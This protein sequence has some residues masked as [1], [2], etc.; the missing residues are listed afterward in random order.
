MIII[1]IF[2]I[3]IVIIIVLLTIITITTIIISPGCWLVWR[4]IGYCWRSLRVC[5]ENQIHLQKALW[6]AGFRFSR[7]PK[8]MLESQRTC[9]FFYFNFPINLIGRSRCFWCR[10]SGW[11]SW[12]LRSWESC[13]GCT[14]HNGHWAKVAKSWF[15]RTCIL[16]TSTSTR[17]HEGM[18]VRFYQS[19]KM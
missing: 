8:L 10:W 7:L 6:I 17:P 4:N 3:T 1:T 15:P 14:L 16:H 9:I 12:R 18:G 5:V 13:K 11:A 19:C 2:I